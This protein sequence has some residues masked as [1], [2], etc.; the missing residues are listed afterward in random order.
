M[1][2]TVMTYYGG[3]WHAVMKSDSSLLN[4]RKPF[5]LPEFSSEITA[6]ECVVVRIGRM[7]RHIERRFASRYT[8]GIA[9][10][11]NFRAEDKLREGD[12]AQALAFDNALAVGTWLPPE[13]FPAELLPTLPTVEESIEKIS[14]IMTLRTGDM[15]FIDTG[16]GAPVKR[17]QVFSLSVNGTENL[18]CKIK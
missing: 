5:F 2:I 8:D 1:K 10:G 15:I 6:R 12:S 7:G 11:L 16:E 18:Y 3:G 4:Q 13:E 9:L 17:E 14:G